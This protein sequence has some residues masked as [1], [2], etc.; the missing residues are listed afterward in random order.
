MAAILA[1]DGLTKNFGGLRAVDSVSLQFE[2]EKLTSVIGPNGAG[3]S[4]TIKILTTLLRK[5]SGSATVAGFDRDA[6]RIG[7]KYTDGWLARVQALATVV[8]EKGA[9]ELSLFAKAK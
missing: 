5:T 3:K 4:T 1:T 7:P 9:V 2:E 8:A 6:Y